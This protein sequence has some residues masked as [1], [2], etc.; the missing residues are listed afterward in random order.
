V[1]FKL[2]CFT[3]NLFEFSIFAPDKIS[4]KTF[5]FGLFK[6]FG[7]FHDLILMKELLFHLKIL[8]LSG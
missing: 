1:I 6:D 7:G 3:K 8:V 2:N 4:R 5:G